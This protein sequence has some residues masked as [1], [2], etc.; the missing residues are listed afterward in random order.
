MSAEATRMQDL[1]SEFTKKF[2]GVTPQ[3]PTAGGATPSRTHPQPEAG[4]G[5]LRP[6]V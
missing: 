4:R 3:T 2:L 1:A 5:A 6:G